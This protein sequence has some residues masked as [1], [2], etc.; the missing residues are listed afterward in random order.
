MARAGRRPNLRRIAL[1]LV[2]LLF[3]LTARAGTVPC[4]FEGGAVV[5][6]ANL[7]GIAGDFIL[8]T[9]TEGLQLHE[10]RAQGE[11]LPSRFEA[12]LRLAGRTYRQRAVEVVDLDARTHAFPTPIAGVIGA[13]VIGEDVLDLS[14]AP[15]RVAL[16]SP[17]RA[18]RRQA[19]ETIRL[20]WTGLRPVIRATVTDGARIRQ[21]WFL[22]A[23]SSDAALRLSTE[24]VSLADQTDPGPLLPYGPARRALRVMSVGGILAENLPTGL[25]QPQGELMGTIGPQI[26]SGWVLR[27]QSDRLSLRRDWDH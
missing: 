23:T 12:D 13:G 2:T 7:G 27:L 10:T 20:G 15:C 4:W 1:A 8:D 24:A 18:P 22:L 11:G 21:G 16:F 26:F 14:F 6:P 25:I 5:V 19:E 3:P 9:A 17:G